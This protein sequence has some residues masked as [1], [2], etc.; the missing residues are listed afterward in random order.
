MEEMEEREA[1]EEKERI[2]EKNEVIE[3]LKLKLT[4]MHYR[5]L[6]RLAGGDR[7]YLD[8][9]VELTNINICQLNQYM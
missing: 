2:L 5:Q 7:Q 3:L 1:K 9:L 8:R 6:S 4:Y